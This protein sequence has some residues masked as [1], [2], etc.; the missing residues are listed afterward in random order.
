MYLYGYVC[1]CT[2]C[3]YVNAYVYVYV[4]VYVYYVNVN[5]YVYVY[6]Y[7]YCTVYVIKSKHTYAYTVYI[8]CIDGNFHLDDCDA[9]LTHILK[10]FVQNQAAIRDMTR[11]CPFGI[12]IL[13]IFSYDHPV[14]L[15]PSITKHFA[16]DNNLELMLTYGRIIFRPYGISL[17]RY[18]MSVCLSVSPECIYV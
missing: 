3:L 6:V 2:V 18:D 8:I 13:I 11:C 1:I 17:K 5:V 4:N 16:G 14:W 10:S 15:P 12:S 7:V 9:E